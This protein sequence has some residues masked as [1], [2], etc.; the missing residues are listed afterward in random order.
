MQKY[1]KYTH[2]QKTTATKFVLTILFLIVLIASSMTSAV[3]GSAVGFSSDKAR[4]LYLYKVKDLQLGD[5]VTMGRFNNYDLEWRITKKDDNGIMLT[6]LHFLSKTDGN[7]LLMP[8]SDVSDDTPAGYPNKKDFINKT[9][10][11]RTSTSKGTS[12]MDDGTNYWEQS[13]IRHYLNQDFFNSAFTA[14]QKAIFNQSP[15]VMQ[16]LGWPETFATSNGNMVNDGITSTYTAWVTAGANYERDPEVVNGD[17]GKNKYF[18][19]AED[20][21]GKKTVFQKFVDGNPKFMYQRTE[22]RGWINGAFEHAPYYFSDDAVFIAQL[23][24][25]MAFMDNIN[26]GDN[27]NYPQDK[28]GNDNYKQGT[29]FPSLMAASGG[30]S[31]INREILTLEKNL[32]IVNDY[33]RRQE[34]AWRPSIYLNPESVLKFEGAFG[35][36]RANRY[37]FIAQ[38]QLKSPTIAVN[39]FDTKAGYGVT[40]GILL[41]TDNVDLKITSGELPPGINLVETPTASG[42][43]SWTLEGVATK[44]NNTSD[45]KYNFTITATNIAGS[46]STSG[47]YIIV[48]KGDPQ[49]PPGSRP[50]LSASVGQT[51]DDIRDQLPNG[52]RFKWDDGYK[53][54]QVN[55][56]QEIEAYYNPDRTS[57]QDKEDKVIVKVSAGQHSAPSTDLD[58]QLSSI[59]LKVDQRLGDIKLPNSDFRWRDPDFVPTTS[60]NASGNNEQVTIFYNTDTVNWS[61]YNITKSL[62]VDYGDP[63]SPPSIPTLNAVYGQVLGDI[64]EQIPQNWYFDPTIP[65]G[66]AGQNT[67]TLQY[68]VDR[69][70]YLDNPV[71]ISITVDKAQQTAPPFT[72]PVFQIQVGQ[73]LSTINDQISQLQGGET[74]FAWS[75]PSQIMNLAGQN[76]V[77]LL[78]N[79]DKDNL[80]TLSIQASILVNKKQIDIPPNQ[81]V[82]ETYVGNTIANLMGELATKKWQFVNEDDLQIEFNATG[83]YEFDAI[84]NMDSTQYEDYFGTVIVDVKAKKELA[85]SQL[86]VLTVRYGQTIDDIQMSGVSNPEYFTIAEVLDIDVLDQDGKFIVVGSTASVLIFYNTDPVNNAPYDDIATCFVQ[87]GLQSNLPQA[88]SNLTIVKGGL[89]RDLQLPS[90]FF[91]A[92]PLLQFNTLGDGIELQLLYNTDRDKYEDVTITAYIKVTPVPGV[93]DWFEQPWFFATTSVVVAAIIFTV[94]FLIVRAASKNNKKRVP[95]TK[96]GQRESG[97]YGVRPSSYGNRTQMTNDSYE[98]TM[99]SNN[100]YTQNGY[101]QGGY[102]GYGQNGAT[103]H[104]LPPSTNRS[105]NGTRPNNAGYPRNPNDPNNRHSR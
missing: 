17:P 73:A 31:S 44:V 40:K 97:N 75:D 79:T 90:G 43:A 22:N 50:Q 37:S 35:T 26:F 105:P 84:Y 42:G 15:Q 55:S 88:P 46:Q 49:N 41:N 93:E 45:L 83:L 30:L 18:I 16:I 95:T 39:A 54:E 11:H 87:K 58:N 51:T 64:A 56:A 59:V 82:V 81:L 68:N 104:R 74:D 76:F 100:S 6:A 21:T 52:W 96:I 66:N 57:Y 13:T 80:L 47:M 98:P 65:V 33:A 19:S 28:N 85:P 32:K 67:L 23:N 1:T 72:L 12:R 3:H 24:D 89:A 34:L 92:N 2:S 63:K 78:Y 25:T 7:A 86:P 27:I 77:T 103:Q 48:N 61:D 60:T 9:I 101:G 69:D 38:D 20:Y 102:G 5:Y 53:F 70:N 91:V 62:R 8:F 14:E 29:S 4:G 36:T 71:D 99:Q 94:I 10:M